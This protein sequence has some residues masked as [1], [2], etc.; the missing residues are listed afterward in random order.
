MHIFFSG[1]GGMG[2]GPLAL[3][4]LQAGYTVSGSD[5][6]QS[7]YLDTLQKKGLTNLYVGQSE[8]AIAKMHDKNPIDWIVYS[9]A[10]EKEQTEHPELIF[11]K[12]M[13]YEQ[14]NVMSSCHN[15]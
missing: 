1:V 2:I 9:S 11:A 4:A 7:S 10:V 5:K 8:D 15:Y 12:K 6:Q 14:Q 13:A 3:I